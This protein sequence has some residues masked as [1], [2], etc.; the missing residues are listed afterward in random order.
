MKT[1]LLKACLGAILCSTSLG[2]DAPPLLKDA[3]LEASIENAKFEGKD[4]S[5]S[6]DFV[7]KNNTGKTIVIAERWNSWGAFQ[8][9][10]SVTTSDRRLIEFKNPQ[11][12]WTRNFLSAARIE[13]GKELRLPCKLVAKEPGPQ[14]P[15]KARE[16]EIELFRSKEESLHYAFPVRLVG[17]FAASFHGDGRVATNWKG[18]IQT[19]EVELKQ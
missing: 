14:H 11:T 8:W 17:T 16:N 1:I 3:V 19:P 2:E 12:A 18:T 4:S 15:Y 6:L 10:L 9:S 7:L 13:P 5:I